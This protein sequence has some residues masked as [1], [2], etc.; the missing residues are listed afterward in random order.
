MNYF[1][2]EAIQC[3]IL[4]FVT[5]FTAEKTETPGPSAE[6]LAGIIVAVIL[7]LVIVIVIIVILNRRYA[8]VNTCSH[9]CSYK[10]VL[11]HVLI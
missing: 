3:N 10:H 9:T 1:G 2:F 6:V 11:V 5:Y 8:H 7:V 4:L